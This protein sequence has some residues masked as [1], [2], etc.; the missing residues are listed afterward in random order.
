MPD[1]GSAPNTIKCLST[2]DVI[3][4][5]PTVGTKFAPVIPDN[6]TAL[7][8]TPLFSVHLKIPPFLAPIIKSSPK[9]SCV[10]NLS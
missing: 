5:N 10:H 4:C 6:S 8:D 3:T 9:L 7:V 1:I 2:S